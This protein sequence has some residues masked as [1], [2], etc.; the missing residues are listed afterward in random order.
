MPFELRP[1][2]CKQ[3]PFYDEGVVV[4]EHVSADGLESWFLYDARR[5]L[6]EARADFL[7]LSHIRPVGVGAME[8][9]SA[10]GFKSNELREATEYGLILNLP[11]R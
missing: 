3:P 8:F 5:R 10:W 6:Y 11:K 1:Q 2:A 4:P 9:L 7:R